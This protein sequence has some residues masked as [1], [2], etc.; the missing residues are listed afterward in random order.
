MLVTIP[1]TEKGYAK[2]PPPFPTLS[3]APDPD[4]LGLPLIGG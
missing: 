1:G 4:G 2:G 3:L